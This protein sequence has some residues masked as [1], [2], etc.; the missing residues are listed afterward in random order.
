[1][2][3]LPETWFLVDSV[4]EPRRAS[5]SSVPHRMSWNASCAY[6]GT[7]LPRAGLCVKFRHTPVNRGSSPSA[8]PHAETGEW[9]EEESSS[10]GIRGY[11]LIYS[12][13][14]TRLD[15][16][17]LTQEGPGCL[18]FGIRGSSVHPGICAAPVHR[19]DDQ[20]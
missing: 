2:G 11:T 8:N 12:F 10:K 14:F 16:R 3:G 15:P 4:P 1:M 19:K 5:V 20:S 13:A 17:A 7:L 18:R 6:L 9:G